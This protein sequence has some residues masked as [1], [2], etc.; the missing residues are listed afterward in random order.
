MMLFKKLRFALPLSLFILVILIL[1][2]G[3]HLH[4]NL[5]P[6]PLIDKPAPTFSLP[7]LFDVKRNVTKNDL[8]GRVTLV[9]V[10]AT[11]CVSCKEEHKEL[12][13]LA[14]QEQI[15]FVGLNYKDD[16]LRAKKWLKKHGNPYQIVLLDQT[17]MAAIDWGVYGTPE[18]FV[19]DKKGVI[20]YKQIGPLDRKTWE[21]HIK[22][23]ITQLK[24][25]IV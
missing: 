21:N 14:S 22:P 16:P 1:W 10:W 19:L 9:N 5:I 8:L 7:N 12:M 4:P 18:T 24:N 20:R 11:W 2:C 3:L 6:S 25:E 15:Y 13:Q 23:L 17:G